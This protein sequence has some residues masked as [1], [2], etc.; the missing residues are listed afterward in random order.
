MEHIVDVV[1]HLEG[2]RQYICGYCD[3]SKTG[4]VQRAK[5]ESMK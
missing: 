2:D 5:L 4:L 1:L 3:V